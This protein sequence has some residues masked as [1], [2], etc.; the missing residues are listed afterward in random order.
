[1]IDRR[2]WIRKQP[3]H[4]SWQTVGCCGDVDA[5]DVRVGLR[6]EPTIYY[7][8]ADIRDYQADLLARMNRIDAVMHRVQ[9]PAMLIDWEKARL[10]VARF[11]GAQSAGI[12][13]VWILPR[14]SIL[15]PSGMIVSPGSNR[16]MWQKGA[17]AEK[18]I[19]GWESVA[20]TAQGA[21]M[22]TGPV[23]SPTPSWAQSLVDLPTHWAQS[24]TEGPVRAATDVLV[25]A[26]PYLIGGAALVGLVAVASL[27]KSVRG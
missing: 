11:A 9:N 12:S 23:V 24:A 14:G 2:P 8:D 1:V 18:I 25:S 7:S 15:A 20:A 10:P 3:H 17:T 19:E 5:G 22:Q 13:G 26:R 6:T 27:A 21:P 16:S 4:P